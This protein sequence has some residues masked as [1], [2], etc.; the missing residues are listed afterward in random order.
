MV[1]DILRMVS[2]R[3][4]PAAMWAQNYRG[5]VFPAFAKLYFWQR[6]SDGKACRKSVLDLVELE[7]TICGTYPTAVLLFSFL[8][9]TRMFQYVDIISAAWNINIHICFQLLCI[10]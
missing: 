5:K 10:M 8:A 9:C 7:V 3:C 4:R 2:A 6:L 1:C